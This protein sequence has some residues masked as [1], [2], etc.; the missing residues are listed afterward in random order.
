MARRRR[1]NRAR[2]PTYKSFMRALRRSR[3]GRKLEARYRRFHGVKAVPSVKLIGT[4]GK[5]KN[6]FMVGD[7]PHVF[8][9]DHGRERKIRYPGIVAS[10][11]SGTQLWV[12]K[13]GAP[14]L[15]TKWRPLKSR[16]PRTDYVVPTEIEK[17]R[18][19]DARSKKATHTF[20]TH[21]HNESGGTPPRAEIDEYGN[22]RYKRG[23]YRVKG[24]W[25]RR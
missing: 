8:V 3:D 21:S 10:N 22:I 2:K 7:T 24:L 18:A 16:I 15:G 5:R 14:G 1:R 17:L 25:L 11:A 19:A 9:E 20:W 13:K 4:G 12:I 23:T 6:L